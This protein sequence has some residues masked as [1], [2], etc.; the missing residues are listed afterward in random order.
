MISK[1]SFG[2]YGQY[3]ISCGELSVSIITLGATVTHLRRGDEE[4][5][6]GYDSPEGFLQ[7]SSYI[8]AIVGRYANRIRGGR[9][10]INGNAI[11]LTCNEGSN[12]LHGGPDAFDRMVW[13]TEICG[14]NAVTFRYVSPDGENGFPGTLRAAVTYTLTESTLRLDFYGV[15][16]ADT[17]FAPTSHMYFRLSETCFQT[18]L[19]MNAESYLP[20]DNDNLPLAPEKTEGDYDF[21]VLRPIRQDYDHCFIPAGEGRALLAG[22]KTAIAVRTDFPAMQ[23]YTGHFLPPDFP[24]NY[25][26][27][28]EPEFCPDSPNRPEFASPVLKAGE[29]FHRFAEYRII[30]VGEVGE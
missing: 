14:E 18:R 1:D 11:Q 12:Q 10:V 23:L 22:D 24:E 3:T 17:L 7:G 19:R 16:D 21:S 6:L 25:G 26:V 13:E 28:L 27:A 15:S 20:T 29:E 4:L 2:E 30:D 5:L 8:N 9:C